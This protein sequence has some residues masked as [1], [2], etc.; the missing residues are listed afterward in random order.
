MT[1]DD[2]SQV[3]K[4]RALRKARR[5]AKKLQGIERLP[6]QELMKLLDRLLSDGDTKRRAP[7]VRPE[8]I[9][10]IRGRDDAFP[11]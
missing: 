6:G 10:R 2:D 7:R 9:R 4:Q 1:I 3:K 5:A 8:T 11:H